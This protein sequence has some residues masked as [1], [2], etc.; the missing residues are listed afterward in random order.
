[1]TC[2]GVGALGFAGCSPVV[3]T[4]LWAVL[5]GAV[6]LG[7]E[8]V[9]SL[10]GAG[11]VMLG[12]LAV[13]ARA[14]DEEPLSRLEAGEFVPP[15]A[16]ALEALPPEGADAPPL[17]ADPA[18]PDTDD[19]VLDPVPDGPDDVPAAPVEPLLLG[20]PL[21]SEPDAPPSAAAPPDVD[22]EEAAPELEPAEPDA[23]PDV[24]PALPPLEVPPPSELEV[25]PEEAVPELE[26]AEP[27]AAPDVPPA[28][29]PLEVPPPSEL[30]VPPPAAAP[31]A[32]EAAA[33]A[34]VDPD[35]DSAAARGT[36][37]GGT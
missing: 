20:E 17:V 32:L 11:P 37:P 18:L 27:D 21:A 28:L 3:A 33:P 34:P 13:A 6:S 12:A 35:V 30:D 2:R 29:P 23:A 24:P 15:L 1:M 8:T 19:A 4:L 25:D 16:V 26:P 9:C 31:S 14:L 5:A 36:A 7:A 22:P 10:A